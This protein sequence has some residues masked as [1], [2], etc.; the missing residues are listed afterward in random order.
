[1]ESSGQVLGLLNPV[2]RCFH[3]VS[4]IGMDEIL[5]ERRSEQMDRWTLKCNG[6]EEYGSI[7]IVKIK[8]IWLVFHCRFRKLNNFGS[9][10]YGLD[11]NYLEWC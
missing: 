5:K 7:S 2:L 11:W 1:M 10:F 4:L 6:D 9:W 8:R 3:V